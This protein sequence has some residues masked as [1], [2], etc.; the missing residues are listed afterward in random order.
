MEQHATSPGN[1][2]DAQAQT[3][4]SINRSI[5]EAVVARD[6]ERLQALYADDFV[7]THGTGLVQTKAEWLDSIRDKRT[8]FIS[9]QL[10]MTSVEIHPD[11]AIVTGRLLVCRQSES[12]EATYGLQYVRVYSSRSGLWQL[13]SHRT[14]SQWDV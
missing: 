5:E 4:E 3:V 7:F 2:I 12:D 6:M 9:R 10:D 13:V 14:L 11:T 8:R 1:M